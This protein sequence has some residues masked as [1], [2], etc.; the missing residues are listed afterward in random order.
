MGFNNQSI[1]DSIKSSGK[2][3]EKNEDNLKGILDE[4]VKTFNA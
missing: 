4:F 3:E 2:L 1:F